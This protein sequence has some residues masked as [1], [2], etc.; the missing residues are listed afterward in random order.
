MRLQL[1]REG[2]YAVRAVLALAGHR[3]GTPLSSRRMA[4]EWAIP[5]RFLPHVLRRLANAG[6][7]VPVIGR[8]GGYRLA[9]DPATITLL[10]VVTAIEGLPDNQTCVLRAS[11]CQADG[12]CLVHEAFFAAQ[13][14]FLDELAARTLTTVLASSGWRPAPDRHA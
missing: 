3:H 9:R 1:T 10:E 5:P 12:H 2:N 4:E 11:Q 8:N 6:L 14:R 13:A 7:I